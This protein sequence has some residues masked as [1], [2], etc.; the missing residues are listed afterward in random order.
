M[1][2]GWMEFHNVS[3]FII[4]D[5]S[6]AAGNEGM[7]CFSNC[8]GSSRTKSAMSRMRHLETAVRNLTGIHFTCP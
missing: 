7:Q 4:N 5:I 1:T 3:S 6:L 2:E 8:N